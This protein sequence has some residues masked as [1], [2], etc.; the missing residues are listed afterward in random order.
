MEGVKQLGVLP[1]TAHPGAW[2][3]TQGMELAF[4][5][6]VGGNSRAATSGGTRSRDFKDGARKAVAPVA[7]CLAGSADFAAPEAQLPL[8]VYL[9]SHQTLPRAFPSLPEVTST[10]CHLPF[11]NNPTGPVGLVTNIKHLK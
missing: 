9:M 1:P 2:W 5:S 6:R 7:G 8:A 3:M 10:N 4:L 11:C